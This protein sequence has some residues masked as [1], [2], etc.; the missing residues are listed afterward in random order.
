MDKPA[1]NAVRICLVGPSPPPSGGMANQ[2]LQLHELLV[3]ENIAVSFVRTNAPY[4]PQ[5]VERIRVLRAVFRLL[6][7][8]L[9]LWRAAKNVDV[10]HVFANSGISWY[11][12]TL[13]AICVAKITRVPVIINYRGGLADDFLQSS[14]RHVKPALRR[15]SCIVVPS[16]FLEDVFRRHGFES[17]TIPNIIDID[18]FERENM[19]L[20]S[21]RPKSCHILVSRNLEKIYGVSFALRAFR[22]VL[23]QLT[24]ATMT[25]AGDGPEIDSLIL[26]AKDLDIY[27]AITFTG[28]V[29]NR[30]MPSLYRD[31]TV[32]VNSSRADNMPISILESLA[33]GIPVVST[34]AGG[35]PFLV[36]HRESA[37]LVPVDDYERIAEAV[38][39]LHHNRSLASTLV[40]NGYAI[41]NEC[42]W[43]NVRKRWL[44]TYENVTREVP[45]SENSAL[46][47]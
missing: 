40:R 7:Y 35:I 20:A 24:D 45:Q 16:R 19:E 28:Q 30:M 39:E 41:A 25:I 34:D 18:R 17:I 22:L 2:A 3:Q 27:Q 33:S 11:V 31:A 44:Q 43:E 8:V 1:A 9:K 12:F 46:T 36:K 15:A 47:K 38:L 6:P 21:A 5:W 37:L 4:N 13:P 42:S 26:L 14:G 32:S 23:I 10:F 29:D